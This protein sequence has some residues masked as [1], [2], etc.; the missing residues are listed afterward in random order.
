MPKVFFEKVTWYGMWIKFWF[1]FKENISPSHYIM[2]LSQNASK[3]KDST[4]LDLTT[5]GQ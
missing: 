1:K 5:T 3:E 4:E 2:L